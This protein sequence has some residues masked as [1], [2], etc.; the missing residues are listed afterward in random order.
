MFKTIESLFSAV[1]VLAGMLLF[2]SGMAFRIAGSPLA[3][4]WVEE[5]TV[6]LVA[7]GTLLA[8]A[9]AV[10]M[11]E[12]VRV[13]FFLEMASDRV[14]HLSQVLAALSGLAFCVAMTVFGW[15]VVEFARRWDE[16]GPSMLQMPMAWYYLALP[17]SMAFCSLRYVIRLWEL[18]RPETARDD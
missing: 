1:L 3:G 15:E 12:H 16:R 2:L 11:N 5:V 7:W 18:L 6:Y 13:D 14:K 8:A 17:T 4:G 10:A 9:N